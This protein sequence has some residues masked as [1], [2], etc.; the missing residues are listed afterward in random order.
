[1]GSTKVILPN[2][3]CQQT[4]AHRDCTIK[5]IALESVM[6]TRPAKNTPSK[7]FLSFENS[8]RFLK[9]NQN[10]SQPGG[11]ISFRKSNSL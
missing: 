3:L 1:M 5:F 6:M 8:S 9:N 11:P 4:L 7:Q 10:S 2:K